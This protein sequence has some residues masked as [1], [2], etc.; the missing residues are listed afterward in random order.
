MIQLVPFIPAICFDIA[1]HVIIKAE[2][3]TNY[4]LN[5]ETFQLP[6]KWFH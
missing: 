4:Y 5:E 2:E 1:V 6:V 3:S